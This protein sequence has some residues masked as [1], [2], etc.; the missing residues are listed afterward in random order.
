M[1]LRTVN[2]GD[3]IA[4]TD[5]NDLVLAFTV[6]EGRVSDLERVGGSKVP[7]RITKVLP[8]GA[9]TAGD[10][11][12]IFGSNFDVSKTGYSV[13]FGNTR[14]TTFDAAHSSDS[15]L[16][17]QIPD[18]VDGA[19]ASGAPI[20]M[21][22]ANLTDS[23]TWP[24]TVK[25]KPVLVGGGF[26]FGY[27][28]SVPDT[29][30]S[31]SPIEYNFRL[32]SLSNADLAVSV[33]A[34]IQVS[35]V[36][37][38]PAYE[39]HDADGTNRPDRTI[40]LVQGGVKTITVR[41]TV[42]GA[43]LLTPFTLTATAS[44]TGFQPVTEIV[45]PQTVG[46]AGEIPDPTITNLTWNRALAGTANFTPLSGGTVA[47]ILTIPGTAAATV[48]IA[49][50]TTFANIPAGNTYHYVSSATVVSGAGWTASARSPSQYDIP[51]PG[52]QR[53]PNFDINAPDVSAIPPANRTPAF[54]RFTLTHTGT[55]A[56]ANNRRS[57]TFRVERS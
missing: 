27:L 13:R 23:A 56:T 34:D 32:A 3:V 16:I 51:S 6:L 12:N 55:G 22:V 35:G 15:L 1:T 37:G 50:D 53:F 47:G 31:S 43:P 30:A 38:A 20:T 28:N 45:P 2:P 52:A 25:S 21:T 39:V 48:S 4:S 18:Q 14:A 33:Q 42:P 19:T 29:P 46:V 26:E 36:S 7:P 40:A 24:L 5:W 11:I 8:E 9:R 54:I 44:A 49:L 10:W 57:V 17:V 41:F